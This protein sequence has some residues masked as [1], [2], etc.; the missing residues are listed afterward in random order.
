MFFCFAFKNTGI[1]SD[2]S[3]EGRSNQC[4]KQRPSKRRGVSDK[5]RAASDSARPVMA[6][7]KAK[8]PKS[9]QD[10][11]GKSNMRINHL[12][13]FIEH[14]VLLL[15][16]RLSST[17]IAF[18]LSACPSLVFVFDAQKQY[19]LRW[20]KSNMFVSIE[21]SSFRRD[22]TAEV[23][24]RCLLASRTTQRLRLRL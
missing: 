20:V 7:G 17:K 15:A 10:R 22:H 5:K 9:S 18:H 23:Q 21:V 16:L 1:A 2:Q 8:N 19:E 24:S 3:T 14:R 4:V 12:N 13:H 11:D 6:W